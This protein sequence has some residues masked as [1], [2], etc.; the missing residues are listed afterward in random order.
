MTYEGWYAFKQRNQN[1]NV[2]LF[3]VQ[4]IIVIN[5]YVK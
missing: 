5:G 3:Y 2:M 4:F 1:M